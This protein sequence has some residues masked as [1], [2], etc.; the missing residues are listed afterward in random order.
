[1]SIASTSAPRAAMTTSWDD[2]HP[3]DLRVAELLAKYGLSGTFYV[4]IEGQGAKMTP[5][6]LRELSETFEIGSHTVH[7]KKLTLLSDEQVGWELTESR[8]RLED[9]TGKPCLTF[10]PVGGKFEARHLTLVRQAGYVSM[11]TVELLSVDFPRRR[12]NLWVL[13]TTLQ[14][15]DHASEV[16]LKN[17]AKRFALRNLLTLAQAVGKSWLQVAESLLQ[18]V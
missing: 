2:G 7:E 12:E 18:R 15:R 16:Y 6:Q 17:V 8:S 14:V 11:R 3:L 4:P 1:M 9:L 5:L 13:P 10:S